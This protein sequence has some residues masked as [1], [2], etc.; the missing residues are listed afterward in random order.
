M[1]SIELPGQEACLAL[2]EMHETP[3][4]IIRHCQMVWEVG[5]VLGAGLLQNQVPVDMELI[6][7]SCLLHDIGKYPCLLDGTHY[8]DV[9]GEQMLE[10]AGL[11]EVARIVVQHV[12]LRGRP[13]DPIREEHVLFYAD[14]R[15]VHDKVVSLE[16]RFEY[17]CETYG[18]SSGAVS[19][20]LSMKEE[21]MRLE[22][23]IFHHLDFTPDEVPSLLDSL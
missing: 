14:K 12:V 15:V 20:L 13:S 21:T 10:E 22:T 19:R 23:R 4:H 2:L 3:V 11:P 6:R 16:E 17:L 9:R 18:K 8:H 1:A 7:A 5:R